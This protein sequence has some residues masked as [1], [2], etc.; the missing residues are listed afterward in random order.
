MLSL[1]LRPNLSICSEALCG[2]QFLLVLLQLNHS[3]K[4][5]RHKHR[6]NQERSRDIQITA[7][8]GISAGSW[9]GPTLSTA[10]CTLHP[11][12]VFG[13]R[14]G[15]MLPPAPAAP[16]SNRNFPPYVPGL[17]PRLSHDLS[18]TCSSLPSHRT[19]RSVPPVL[20]S[21]RQPLKQPLVET[22]VRGA[23]SWRAAAPLPLGQGRERR[24]IFRADCEP[25]REDPV[26]ADGE[27]HQPRARHVDVHKAMLRARR[28]LSRRKSS[29]TPDLRMERA[30]SMHSEES[31]AAEQAIA[32]AKDRIRRRLQARVHSPLCCTH[33]C[34]APTTVLHPPCT[35]HCAASTE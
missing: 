19:A 16:Q 25:P 33:H 17:V 34:A 31:P 2:W 1:A 7:P 35:H 5:L 21:A 11:C 32:I 14:R 18:P 27:G 3:M 6:I 20:T 24:E 22:P 8:T 12:V 26:E 30:K 10:P 28:R 13:R 4:A 15:Q 29:Q 9:F 23:Q